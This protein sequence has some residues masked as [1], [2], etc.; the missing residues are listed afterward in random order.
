MKWLKVLPITLYLSI[1]P[2][3]ATPAVY[4]SP[5]IEGDAV[6]VATGKPI[7]GAVVLA[8]WDI[9]ES[10]LLDP[11]DT[12]SVKTIETLTDKN[13][14]FVI[15]SW[16]PTTVCCGYMQYGPGLIVIKPGYK[17]ITESVGVNLKDPHIQPQK[18]SWSG[19]SFRMSPYVYEGYFG[20]QGFDEF[21]ALSSSV[22]VTPMLPRH[23]CAL[24]DYPNF[25]GALTQQIQLFKAHGYEDR[26][27]I[28]FD[29]KRSNCEK[30][31]GKKDVG[32]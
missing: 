17:P 16:G 28:I 9:D 27:S 14:H 12:Y 18:P 23:P 6:D 32:E 29:S 21:E 8:Y 11:P 25:M 3:C 10:H 4:Q 1:L 7:E 13:G 19:D 22:S 24:K 2:A 30:E 26:N 31:M 20:K 15:P 5:S